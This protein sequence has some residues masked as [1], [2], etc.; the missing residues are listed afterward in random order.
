M[1]T[2][3]GPLKQGSLKLGK[4]IAHILLLSRLPLWLSK[5]SCTMALQ[6]PV[7]KCC[8]RTCKPLNV[9]AILLNLKNLLKLQ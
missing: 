2:I 6:V 5:G 3:Q 4:L 9:G 8:A 7:A 1:P